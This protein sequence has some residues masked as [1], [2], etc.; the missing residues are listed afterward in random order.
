MR[1]CSQLSP[2][3]CSSPLN[4]AFPIACATYNPTH[5]YADY[6]AFPNLMQFRGNQERMQKNH[7]PCSLQKQHLP[8]CMELFLPTSLSHLREPDTTSTTR[9][10]RRSRYVELQRPTLPRLLTL[11]PNPYC[12]VVSLALETGSSGLPGSGS[13]QVLSSLITT[14]YPLPSSLGQNRLELSSLRA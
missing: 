6:P 10:P 9:A 1:N 4:R 7:Q 13:L 14:P 8:R 11:P 2:C 12:Q 3:A 5:P